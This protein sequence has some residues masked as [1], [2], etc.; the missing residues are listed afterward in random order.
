M[1]DALTIV[2]M[3]L[4]GLLHASWHSLVKYGGDQ[5]LVLA[6]MGLV[7]AAV[8]AC[9]LPFLPF[10]AA[11]VWAVIGGSVLLHVGYKLALARSYAFGDL[12]QAYPMA[13]GLVPLFATLIAFAA[14]GQTPSATQMA[15]IALVS[16]GLI[17]LAVHSIR[18][19]VDRRLFLA[20]MLAGLTVAGYSV[21]DAY[22]TRLN[23]DWMSFT[24]WLIVCDALTFAA[25]IFCFKGHALWTELWRQRTRMLVSGGLGL[26]SFSVFLWALSRSPVGAISALRESSVLFA[27]ILGIVAYRESASPQKVAAAAVI[28]A[29]LVVITA[30]R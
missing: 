16:G 24:A 21:V 11:P 10:P 19:G 29:G 28:V 9:A 2:L 26:L 4:A 8:S 25:L 13:R 20:A 27:T 30:L 7:A 23:G 14:L 1:L 22:G 18:G 17:W 3:L 6:G 12:G 5:V 15:G